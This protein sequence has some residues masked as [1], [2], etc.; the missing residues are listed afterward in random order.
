MRIQSTAA[1]LVLLGSAS[2]HGV[3]ANKQGLRRK[4]ATNDCIIMAV[5]A[6]SISGEVPEMIIECEVH[7]DDANGIGGISLSIDAPLAQLNELKVLIKSGQVTPGYDSLDIAGSDIDDK[8]VHLP[9]GSDI[10]AMV[11]QNEKKVG[12]RRLVA[13]SGNLKMLLVK[14]TDVNGLKLSDSPTYMR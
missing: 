13:T 9:P 14:V 10:S 6:L 5:E 7:P 3:N 8:A 12:R 2:L 11:R 4:L 1:F